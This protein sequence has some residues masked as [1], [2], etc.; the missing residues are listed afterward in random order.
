MVSL[1][2][3]FL[4]CIDVEI[5][6]E[7]VHMHMVCIDRCGG[8]S[9]FLALYKPVCREF[10][11]FPFWPIFVQIMAMRTQPCEV[12]CRNLLDMDRNLY[13]KSL[14]LI[15]NR[16]SLFSRQIS[17]GVHWTEHVIYHVYAIPPVVS[18]DKGTVMWS[19]YVLCFVM[20]NKLL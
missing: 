11:R 12:L 15:T 18:P 16:Q 8:T 10:V 14:F 5:I 9:L 2:S 6:Q 13:L 19:F 1:T 3:I 7:T 17:H 20:L 4:A